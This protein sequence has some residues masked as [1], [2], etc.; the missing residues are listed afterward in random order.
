M[1]CA[2]QTTSC[3]CTV[4]AAVTSHSSVL[5]HSSVLQL[6]VVFL[7]HL[8]TTRQFLIFLLRPVSHQSLAAFQR[9]CKADRLMSPTPPP[10]SFLAEHSVVWCG[11]FLWSVGVGCPR[12]APPPSLLAGGAAREAET[13]LGCASA[14]QQGLA[15]PWGVEAVHSTDGNHSPLQTTGNR[16]GI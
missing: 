14:A 10:R 2:D 16:C 13:P 7:C 15:P 3:S 1:R 11:I 4:H 5:F 6:S 8:G 12:C 9:L